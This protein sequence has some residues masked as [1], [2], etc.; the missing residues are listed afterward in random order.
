MSKGDVKVLR[1]VSVISMMT[2]VSRVL[3]LVRESI[4][5]YAFGTSALKSAFDIAFTIP[6]LFRRL[7]GEGALSSAFVPVFSETLVKEGRPQA[8]LLATRVISLLIMALGM[9]T[10]AGIFITWPLAKFLPAESRWLLPLPMLR[11]MLPYALFIC[12]AALL[13][14]SLNALSYFA[15]PSLT[16]FLLNAIWI[17]A[18]KWI[19]PYLSQA[20]D[21]QIILLSWA[22]L[23]AGVA[24]VVF[25]LPLLAKLGFRL[26]FVV[27]GLWQDR[28]LRQILRLMAPA[29]LGL[30]VIQ[31]NVCLDKLLAFWADAAAP[32][33]LEYAE[34]LIYLPLGMF[35]TAFMTVLLPTFSRQVTLHDF[36]AVQLTMERALRN[37]A[38]IMAPCSLALMALA[39]PL[40]SLIYK[41]KSGQFDNQSAILSARALTAYA[42]GLLFF[43]TQKVLTPLFYA[44]K[45]LKTPLR[46]SLVG[47]VLN[48]SMNISSVILLPAGWKH[49]GIAGSTVLTSLI[50]NIMLAVI[51]RHR[52]RLPGARA[53]VGTFVRALGC[54]LV[55]AW[56]VYRG[57]GW[58]RAWAQ[59]HG[60]E[61]KLF[62]IGAM[63]SVVLL[64][65]VVYG[66]LMWVCSRREM[67]E[68]MGEFHR[69]KRARGGTR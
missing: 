22:V 29:A 47:L 60:F 4:M 33:A 16:P 3:G 11:I 12:V 10:L 63:G 30:G 1:S 20:P 55:M 37:L 6:N 39:L 51:L 49:V 48:V 34:R 19:I 21:N 58:L 25:Q 42:P 50:N 35:G 38:V 17:V 67:R 9:L 23:G 8:F 45:D 41:F 31:I 36:S 44:M 54:A 28:R 56:A 65:V 14:G 61:N 15:I 69:R 66:G 52:F 2:A 18:L 7:F 13:S 59:L 24:Q 62:E 32:S 27:Q 57:H 46:V 53:V 40:I 26:R 68:M 5:A 64:G 43:G